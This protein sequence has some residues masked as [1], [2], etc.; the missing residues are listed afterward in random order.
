MLLPLLLKGEPLVEQ[1]EVKAKRQRW[2]EYPA[3]EKLEGITYFG[4]HSDESSL[5]FL[6]GRVAEKV[7][8]Q[9]CKD[10]ETHRYLLSRRLHLRDLKSVTLNEC[11]LPEVSYEGN[12]LTKDRHVL[13]KCIIT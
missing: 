11:R 9:R 7:K 5:K 10:A 3:R 4:C 13:L 2:S 6:L 12:L 1:E 8:T